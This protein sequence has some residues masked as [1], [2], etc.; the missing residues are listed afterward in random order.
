MKKIIFAVVV[1][2]ALTGS[3]H[4]QT[5]HEKLSAFFF[6]ITFGADISVLKIELRSDPSFKFYHDPN[7]DTTKTIVGTIKSNPNLNP[8]CFGNQVIIQYSSAEEKKVKKV[9]LKWTMNY[10]LEDLATA[11]VDFEKLQNEYQPFFRNFLETNKTGAQREMIHT[12]TLKE[13]P[14]TIIIKLVE[15]TNFTHTVSLE[16]KDTWKIEHIDVL[17][18]KY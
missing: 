11:R 12:L 9:F 7:R 17:K 8:V 18:V 5:I 3:T 15:Y 6:D 10:R 2:I 16:Y 4:A 1:L 14:M 13:S